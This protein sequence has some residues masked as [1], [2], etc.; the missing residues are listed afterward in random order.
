VSNRK[1]RLPKAR[2]TDPETSWAAARSITD[3]QVSRSQRIVYAVLQSRGPMTDEEL[4]SLV[5]MSPSGTRTRRKEL[6]EEGLVRDSG[7]RKFTK[8]GRQ[9]V[10]WEVVQ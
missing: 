3:E 5:A 9:A 10:V 6:V 7:N 1:L 8:T 4:V 2:P